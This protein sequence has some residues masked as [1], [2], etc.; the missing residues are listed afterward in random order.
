M[1]AV[2]GNL[3]STAGGIKIMRLLII[4]KILRLLMV[5]S[6]LVAGTVLQ[7]RYMEKRLETDEIEHCF[8][9]ALIFI[10]I[11][12]IS[13]LPFVIMGYPALDALFEVVSACG[14]VGLSTGIT[15]M[16]LPVLLKTVLCVDM[17]MGRLE[18]IA[19]L[20]VLYPPTW[21]GK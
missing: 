16:K 6:G 21:F 1:M 7:P 20:V 19:V 4:L 5:R 2:G 13:W 3:G 18:I 17:L 9:L 15:S 8:V 10:G 11:I 14:T 12:F